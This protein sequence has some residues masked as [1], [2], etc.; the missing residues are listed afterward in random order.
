MDPL[1]VLLGDF[2]DGV[3]VRDVTLGGFLD[4][5]EKGLEEYVVDG[6]VDEDAGR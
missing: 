6:G 2:G 5:V 4:C 1:E 3:D